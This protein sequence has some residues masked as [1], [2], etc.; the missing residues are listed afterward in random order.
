MKV[1]ITGV[2][3]FLGGNLYRNCI[4]NGINVVGH[5]R[6]DGDLCDAK[7]VKEFMELHNPTHIWHFAANPNSKLD[8]DNFSA[9]ITNNILSTQNLLHY[10]PSGSNFLFASS[11]LVYG[12]TQSPRYFN[13]PTE[14]MGVYGAGKLACEKLVKIYAARNKFSYYNLRLSAVVG[15]NMT[16]GLLPDLIK[17]IK[18]PDKEIELFGAYPGSSKPFIHSDNVFA[19]L[20]RM[21]SIGFIGISSNQTNISGF[22]IVNVNRIASIIQKKLGVKK[23]IIWNPSKVWA[24]DNR[25][26]LIQPSY[27]FRSDLSKSIESITKAIDENI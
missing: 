24:G 22:G 16:H 14:P 23:K 13:S 8:E 25:K 7:H 6:K 9:A 5:S 10:T 27:Q 17:K 12:H 11:V 1:L 3:G 15:P 26:L 21:C 20:N 2:G 19:V 4:V 18:S